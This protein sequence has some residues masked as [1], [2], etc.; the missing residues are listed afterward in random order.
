MLLVPSSCLPGGRQPC[1]S[2]STRQ[3]VAL[4]PHILHRGHLLSFW[5]RLP[6]ASGSSQVHPLSGH[7]AVRLQ[8]RLGVKKSFLS[9]VFSISN[10]CG[11]FLMQEIS[12]HMPPRA[13]FLLQWFTGSQIS[14]LWQE[15][16]KQTNKHKKN[17]NKQQNKNQ[18]KHGHDILQK[19]LKS[20][21]GNHINLIQGHPEFCKQLFCFQWTHSPS[22]TSFWI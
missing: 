2:G 10:N 5:L 17:K 15:R 20:P 8:G 12:L 3:S 21:D 11:L 22:Q 14:R 7:C 6:G 9:Q 4:C 19:K 18:R 1:C 16:K 13:C